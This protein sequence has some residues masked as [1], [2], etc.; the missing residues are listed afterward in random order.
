MSGAECHIN[1]EL[2]TKKQVPDHI[3]YAATTSRW[4]VSEVYLVDR[5]EWV[6]MVGMEIPSKQWCDTD[7]ASTCITVECVTAIH[8]V[9]KVAFSEGGKF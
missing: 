5:Q 8:E 3:S 1:A 7:F 4:F 9:L 2:Y 6:F